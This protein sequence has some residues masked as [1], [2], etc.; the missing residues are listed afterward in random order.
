MTGSFSSTRDLR[1][2]RDPAPL[3][4]VAVSL[5]LAM[6]VSAAVLGAG[7]A[8]VSIGLSFDLPRP[9][10]VTGSLSSCWG[11]SEIRL[12][13]S[14]DGERGPSLLSIEA[15]A[16]RGS[17]HLLGRVDRLLTSPLALVGVGVGGDR[18]RIQLDTSITLDSW[19]S[20]WSA[21][22]L[23]ME[24]SPMEGV[25]LG[26]RF[27]FTDG[28]VQL[29]S[30]DV[31]ARTGLADVAYHAAWND[32]CTHNRAYSVDV[33]S[34][35]LGLTRT[36][37]W[38]P[39][40]TVSTIS[41]HPILPTAD[42]GAVSPEPL[43]DSVIPAVASSRGARSVRLEDVG[44]VVCGAVS[45]TDAAQNTVDFG[46]VMVG[47]T[48]HSRITLSCQMHDFC[49][50]E[51][52]TVSPRL[53]F[54][55]TYAPIRIVIPLGGR[56][57]I[58]IGFA[59]SSVGRFTQTIAIRYC[60][61]TWHEDEP[62]YGGIALGDVEGYYTYQCTTVNIL[63]VGVALAKPEARATHSPGRPV[64]GRDVQFDGS[65]SFDPNPEGAI[66]AYQWDFGDGSTATGVRPVH[67]FARAG[68]HSVRLVVWNNREMASDPYVF[69]VDVS[70]DLVEAAGVT[71]AAVAAGLATYAVGLAPPLL[72]AAVPG[73]ALVVASIIHEL[74]SN[75]FPVD[76]LI[77]RF[78]G[79]WDETDVRQLIE[80]NVPRAR[81]IGYFSSLNAFLVQ[82]PI[83]ADSPSQAAEELEAIGERLA[84]VLPHGAQ[85]GRNYMG[86]FEGKMET[87]LPRGSCDLD[88][89]DSDL[90]AA[91]ETIRA[92]EAWR[93]IADADVQL[94][95]VRIAVIDSGIDADHAE[96]V[97]PLRGRSY[98]KRADG[99][100]QPWY[101]DS[102]GHGTQISGIIGAENG[103]G[104]MNGLLS[105]GSG[106]YEMQ[107]YRVI[108]DMFS[109]WDCLRIAVSKATEE[110]DA[111]A[112]AVEAGTRRKSVVLNISLGWD[113]TAL[114]G[115][116]RRLAR[117]T[118]RELFEKYPEAL[119]VT[120]AGNGDAPGDLSRS[121]GRRIEIG[122]D[123]HA[124]GGVDAPNNLTVAAT[125]ASGTELATW[126]NYGSAIDLAA[127]GENV[128][129]TDNDG[130]YVW[131]VE[132]TSYAAA[133]VSG[134]AA[135]VLSIDPKLTPNEVKK[136]L[137]ASPVRVAAPDGSSIP[138]LDFADAIC[139]AVES[140]HERGNRAMWR[141]I[142]LATV[143]LAM[144]L[145]ILRPF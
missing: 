143:T 93:E 8:T 101:E 70:P 107:I 133:M 34:L 58:Q 121:T 114:P 109:V 29:A 78:P 5:L 65:T 19:R 128:Y 97:I 138:V 72:L 30:F 40:G 144:G 20:L 108:G 38:E 80:R 69:A 59:P 42:P 136:I 145:W 57:D 10:V 18:A 120:S 130:S 103:D 91:Y 118:F 35:G 41:W 95:P 23:D 13:I 113:L 83:E 116:E 16:C 31:S 100:L 125:N 51:D 37:R 53:P 68:T 127:P 64:C 89:L 46:E 24:L 62:V 76:Q 45:P 87:A 115:D 22:R 82:L 140:R 81:V 9:S 3:H 44:C 75:R 73:A 14:D 77:L 67:R 12:E 102:G 119:F 50:L 47:E 86:L 32:D 11:D 43:T 129:T 110:L 88:S 135:A 94:K 27:R 71:G 1:L 54:V 39:S 2:R 63:L 79:S 111:W 4:R 142:G 66:T 134:V 28:G 36:M 26:G 61:A 122:D 123:L 98:V 99:Q 7:G 49:W 90:R 124:P 117:D 15:T 33:P 74:G 56:R 17:F 85:V 84:R 139:R 137:T 25:Q 92:S 105:A 141:S 96:F 55:M 106:H 21:R 6:S 126:S 132:G 60:F 131:R 48:A 104:R 112:T 52:V